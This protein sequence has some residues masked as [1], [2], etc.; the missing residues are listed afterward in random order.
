M[1]SGI[2]NIEAR[3]LQAPEI[4]TKD[5]NLVSPL[6][7]DLKAQPQSEPTEVMETVPVNE[8]FK[9]KGRFQILSIAKR[10]PWIPVNVWLQMRREGNLEDQIIHRSPVME[11]LVMLSANRGVNLFLQHLAGDTTF[12]LALTSLSIGTGTNPVTAADTGLQTPVTSGIVPALL[13]ITA[14][15]TLYSE[16]FLTDG[17]LPD[18]D[19]T[20][21]GLYTG[22]QLFTRAL[23]DPAHEKDPLTD[24]LIVYTISGGV[25]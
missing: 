23:I 10:P 19:Y 9:M 17:E 11:N 16:W 13:S 5:I 3:E 20:E 24:T 7:G 8:R 6:K 12:P 1:K 25:V 18:G 21:L 2:I 4:L 22:T 14:P 15:D